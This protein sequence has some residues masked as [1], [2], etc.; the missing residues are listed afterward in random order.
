MDIKVL[1]QHL[2]GDCLALLAQWLPNGKLRGKEYQ[3]GDLQGSP[4]DSLSINTKTG[5]WKDFATGEA[6]GDL[7]ALY[8]AINS[9]TM[10]EAYRE[11]SKGYQSKSAPPPPPPRP[12][13]SLGKP[14]KGSSPH[15]NGGTHYIYK[16]TD[17]EPLL[18][19]TRK[20]LPDNKKTF[21]PSSYD[22]ITKA[23]VKKIWP[24]NRPLYNLH[25]IASSKNI[26]ITEGEKAAIAAEKFAG[27]YA[28]VTWQGG[29]NAI[30]KT[31]WSP[32]RGK[33]ILIWPDNDEPGLKAAKAIADLLHP[34]NASVKL[35]D[36]SAMADGWDAADT[37]FK[38][39]DQ[40]KA[41]AKNNA[42]PFSGA[43]PLPVPAPSPEQKDTDLTQALPRHTSSFAQTY[44]AL[45]LTC[46]SKMQPYLNTNNVLKILTRMPIMKDL[47]WFDEF[48]CTL[49]TR[50]SYEGGR[51]K[52]LKEPIP[53]VDYH[54]TLLQVFLQEEMGLDK[55]KKM[56]V[57]DAV[58][59]IAHAHPRNAPKEWLSSLSWDQSSRLSTF[60]QDYMGA[61]DSEYMQC[62]SR[63]FWIS[64]V[65]R[66]FRP[67]CKC[68]NMVVLEG[69][70]GAKKSTALGA[71]AGPWFTETAIK[72]SHKDF[73]QVIQGSLIVEI[74]ELSSFYKSD[75]S[76]IKQCLSTRSDKFRAPYER[77]PKV[78]PR[79]CIFAGTTNET[80]YH[81]DPTGA[82][83]YWPV[84][85]G[86]IDIDRI[87]ADRDQL[88][89]EAVHL[90]KA[91]HAWHEV[92]LEEAERM[93]ADRAE[94]DAWE[95]DL[96]EYL[97]QKPRY[98]DPTPY[99]QNGFT[100][101]S[102][103]FKVIGLELA[104]AGKRERNRVGRILRT[105]GFE[106]RKIFRDGRTIHAFY[107]PKTNPMMEPLMYAEGQQED[108]V[109]NY[110][111]ESKGYEVPNYAPKS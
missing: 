45:G 68:D 4:G 39:W 28:V 103:L 91:G 15:L 70:Q 97:R 41:W 24:E 11:L 40:F 63:N 13:I 43:A 1:A 26:L 104:R 100:T 102:E 72:P 36:V 60:F 99:M 10:K 54:E 56:P 32:L 35:L 48:S 107:N 81:S 50:W 74:A 110:N 12:K 65:A 67:G 64:M 88:F 52:I 78:H 7:I 57:K 93:Q 18:Y 98:T 66:I 9:I 61:E 82:R 19:V 25:K 51:L 71:I 94:V 17:G 34:G 69:P 96:M 76:I 29:S 59:A 22:T 6:G 84:R 108:M 79:T 105:N 38:D 8:A 101:T 90:F 80:E 49:F 55:L 89:A 30:S 44:R 37:N 58:E 111:A 3:I 92:P 16:D 85:V 95:D 23:W 27:P 20:D 75:M 83:R 47:V 86:S 2:L 73:Y 42:T 5:A 33:N 46:N 14:P 31:D 62:V 109:L 106:T 77:V 21:C 53:W 87:E